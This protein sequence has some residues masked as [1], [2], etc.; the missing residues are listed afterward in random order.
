[1]KSSVIWNEKR[2]PTIIIQKIKNNAN[3]STYNKTAHFKR[4]CAEAV[5]RRAKNRKNERERK[6]IYPKKMVACSKPKRMPKLLFIDACARI[7]H[8]RPCHAACDAMTIV[9]SVVLARR[10]LSAR[11]IHSRPAAANTIHNSTL[12][13]GKRKT[14]QRKRANECAKHWEALLFF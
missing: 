4:K 3:F 13:H 5:A 8:L 14:T 9:I 6:Y 2:A 12:K 7:Y 10:L 11:F 1:M